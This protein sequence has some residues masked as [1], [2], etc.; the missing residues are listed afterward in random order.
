M[1]EETAPKEQTQPTPE[2]AQEATDWEAKYKE[3]QAQA[4]KHETR[5][6]EN[7]EKAKVY[8]ELKR[9]QMSDA[10]KLA[11]AT[12]RATKAEAELEALRQAE[13]RNATARAVS[14][15][16]GVP[17]SLITGTTREE[18]EASAAAIQAFAKGRVGVFSQDG[19]KPQGKPARTTRDSFSEFMSNQMGI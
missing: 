13:E 8:D 17:Q 4:R 19:N 9:T 2:P 16:T 10:E 7:Y 6:K 12:E 5:A 18:M 11:D 15:A 3:L 1:A 14:E